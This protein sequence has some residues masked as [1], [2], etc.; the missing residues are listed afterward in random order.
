MSE[1]IVF[2]KQKYLDDTKVYLDTTYSSYLFILSTYSLWE[3]I[4]EWQWRDAIEAGRSHDND[5]C[6]MS[7]LCS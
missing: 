2:I 4:C 7:G 6:S 5:K 1:F 3:I